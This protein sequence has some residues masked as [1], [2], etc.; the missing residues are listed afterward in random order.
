MTLNQQ[1][2]DATSSV[3]HKVIG[4]VLCL[5]PFIFLFFLFPYSAGYG[6][7]K[8]TVAWRIY[9]FWGDADW[10]HCM[11][12]PAVVLFLVYY[13]RNKWR[14]LP[15]K[16]AWLGL[17][18]LLFSLFVYWLGYRA[19]IRYVGFAAMH[20]YI[21]GAVWWVLGWRYFLALFF[22]L[23]FLV[24][25]MPLHFLEGMPLVKLRMVMCALSSEILGLL[26][27]E[28]VRIG[29]GLLSASDPSK[30]L[31]RGELFEIGVDNPCSGLRS[32][33][34]LL[35][36]S[37]IF[38]YFSFKSIWKRIALILCSI[39]LAVAGNIVRLLMLVFGTI[40]MGSD[41]AIGKDGGVS[42]FHFVAGIVV[43][44]VAVGGMLIVASLLKKIGHESS[45]KPKTTR[46]KI[47]NQ[48][49]KATA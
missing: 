5:V 7:A 45:Q 28:N 37:A 4:W 1:S 19:N 36:V 13:T 6:Q 24:F 39:P 11:F 47:D 30:N 43:F 9:E 34:A 25:A 15:T 29:T 20:L 14:A 35:M 31:A 49:S 21:V 41:I 46:R 23:F 32:L 16:S 8:K 48:S 22:P 26:G 42:T 10:Q 38:G 40:T 27:I 18:I 2:T 33:F 44:L 17:L 3:L 12:V